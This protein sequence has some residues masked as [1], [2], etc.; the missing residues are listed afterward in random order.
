VVFH[1][2]LANA[3]RIARELPWRPGAYCSTER[4]ACSA[5]W[6]AIADRLVA[7]K[8]VVTT[9]ADLVEHG[10]PTEFG[11]LV[12]VRPDSPLKPFSGR[13]LERDQVTLSTLDHGYYYDDEQLPVV[14][15]PAVDVGVEYRF[16]V[17]ASQVVTGSEYAADGRSAG[18]LVSPDHEAWEYAADVVGRLQEPDPVFVMDVCETRA[19]LRV[20]ELNPFSGADLYS[21]DRPDVV[22]AIEALIG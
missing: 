12:F 20:L 19:G 3:D 6:P 2:S 9:V 11:D 14:V 10:P 7:T 8:Y 22:N 21:C 16:V 13:V 17:V 1:G 15:A 5:W 4:F 18:A